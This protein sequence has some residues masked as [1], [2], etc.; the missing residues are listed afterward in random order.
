MNL[1]LT[2][3]YIPISFI[4]IIPA[5]L[6]TNNITKQQTDIPKMNFAIMG[7]LDS[8]SSTMQVFAINYITSASITILVQQSAIPISMVLSAMFLKAR[9][10]T[11]QYIGAVIV[12][13]GIVAVLLPTFFTSSSSLPPDQLVWVLAIVIS[14]IPSV[15]SS[16]YKEKAL[17]EVDIDVVYLYGWVSVFQCL[18][19]IPLCV[20]SALAVSMP[21]SEIPA[22][23][24][25]GLACLRGVNT[26]T[27]ASEDGSIQ[28][29]DC[30][31]AA[32][33]VSVYLAFN[34][35]YNLLIVVILKE[36]S[37]NILWMASTVIVPLSNVAFSLHFVPNHQPLKTMDLVGLI[38][39]M[40]GLLV[41]RFTAQ[42]YSAL[43]HAMERTISPEEKALRKKAKEINKVA[44]KKQAKMIGLNQI[45][46]LNALVDSRVMMAQRSQLL[47]R[48]PAQVRGDLLMKLG[49]PPSPNV[50]LT[51]PSRRYGATVQSPISIS[52]SSN[53]LFT[54]PSY[55]MS[56]RAQQRRAAQIASP[57]SGGSLK[58]SVYQVEV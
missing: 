49:I 26:I 52:S 48:S 40:S 44:E 46:Y 56:V 9:Y 50:M 20:P 55:A 15:Y 47:F 3:I 54:P 51:P 8:I 21:M 41:Y 37:A 22:N 25:G 34:A 31:M 42:L 33:Y 7:L 19:A 35:V 13:A 2:F 32:T 27:H 6:F 24:Y 23:I 12:M 11:A 58:P 57:S 38:I 18:I 4:Y 1:L 53:G 14:N 17:G 30:S 39:I 36:G 10:S 16:V 28:P 5:Q 43:Q 29:D 45:E